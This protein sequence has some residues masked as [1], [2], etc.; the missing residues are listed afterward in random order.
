MKMQELFSAS[1]QLEIGNTST[2]ES[3][4]TAVWGYYKRKFFLTVRNIY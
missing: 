3:V 4:K 1:E 2:L